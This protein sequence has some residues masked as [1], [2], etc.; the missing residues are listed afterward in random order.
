MKERD[1]YT[2]A[3]VYVRRSR[4]GLSQRATVISVTRPRRKPG[5]LNLPKPR[6]RVRMKD[7]HGR[8]YE[9]EVMLGQ[10]TGYVYG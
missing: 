1:L 8:K 10:I 5:Y 9:I 2:G 6:V 3:E 7:D 4:Y